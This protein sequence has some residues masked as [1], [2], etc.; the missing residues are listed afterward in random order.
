[1]AT[2]QYFSR[3]DIIASLQQRLGYADRAIERFFTHSEG[4]GT[5][6][7]H[8]LSEEDAVYFGRHPG[9]DKH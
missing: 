7:N 6:V 5:L 3:K 8:P 4:H 9:Y 1:M 2:K